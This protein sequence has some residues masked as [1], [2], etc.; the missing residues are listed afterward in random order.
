[1]KQFILTILI[2]ISFITLVNV[3]AQDNGQWDIL[4]E[5]GDFN[6]SDFVNGQVGWIAG[7]RIIFK[8]EDGGETWYSILLD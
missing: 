4:N 8:T 6:T 2:S 1:M 7:G 5:G 3:H